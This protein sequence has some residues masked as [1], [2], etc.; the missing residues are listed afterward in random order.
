M[1]NLWLGW[2]LL[3]PHCVSLQDQ[4]PQ[5]PMVSSAMARPEAL[6]AAISFGGETSEQVRRLIQKRHEEGLAGAE[7]YKLIEK[8]FLLWPGNRL[9]HGIQLY[10][11]LQPAEAHRLFAVLIRSDRTLAQQLGWKLAAAL[12]GKVMGQ[13]IERRLTEDLKNDTLY[14]DLIPEMAEAVSA[15]ELV[16]SYTILRK[17]LFWVH[18]Y[19]FAEA[20]ASLAPERATEDFLE[21][22][23]LAEPEELRQL[24]LTHVDLLVC[25]QI[26]SHLAAHVVPVSHPRVEI[27][28]YYAVSR[29]SA[30]SDG[31]RKVLV[32]MMPVDSAYLAF[33]FVGLPTWTQMAFIEGTHRDYTVEGGRFLGE[34]EKRSAQREVIEEIQSVTR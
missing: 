4:A 28:F 32:G 17:G 3:L 33:L 9:M 25:S 30:L 20:M 15:N 21:Y 23:S 14:D 29:I 26:F 11:A 24:T 1:K 12:P 27:L 18:H 5:P 2:F 8:N 31:A 10:Q 19:A 34:V 6:E 16:D 22:L 7:L 13:E